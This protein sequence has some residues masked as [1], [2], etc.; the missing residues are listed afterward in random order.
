VEVLE[1]IG[2]AGQTRWQVRAAAHNL[3]PFVGRQTEIRVLLEA[4]QRARLGRGQIVAIAGEAGM[5]KSRLVHEFLQD[6]SIEGEFSLRSAA[7]PHDQNTPYQLI[8]GL[9]RSWL[10][11]ETDDTQAEIDEK[12][13]GAMV[14]FHPDHTADLT[15]LRSLLDLPVQDGA[16]DRL[17]AVQRRWRTHEIVRS[18]VLRAALTTPFVLVVEDVHWVDFESQ[19]L[20]ESIID[21]LG[22]AHLLVIATYRPEYQHQW[23]R[24]SYY[25]LVQLRALDGDSSDMLLR[26]LLGDAVDLASLRQRMHTAVPGRDGANA[27]R[28]WRSGQRTNTV[29]ADPQRRRDR[30]PGFRA[31]CSRLSHRPAAE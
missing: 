2:A 11:V 21:G 12:L 1:L 17:D 9:I 30:D 4:L 16:W 5:G 13:V 29:P 20:R 6:P 27:C 19:S 28:D 14:S 23:A 26:S 31:E 10:R 8:A 24:H 7:M 15:P 25:S 18:L 22:A 3:S